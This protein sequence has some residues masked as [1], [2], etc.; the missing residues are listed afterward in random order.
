[1]A[2]L[3]IIYTVRLDLAPD[4]EEEA[5]RWNNGPHI[6]DLL[7]AGF[8]SAV[9]YRSTR[10]DPKY[11][12]LYEL[13]SIDT[14]KTETY[15]NV[16]KNDTWAPKIRHGFLNHSASL[17]KQIVTVKIKETP[18]EF[19][20]PR[21]SANSVGGVRSKYLVTI[22][23]DVA[24]DGVEEFMQ[25]NR[26]EHFHLIL[27]I[28]GMASARLCRKAGQHPKNPSH[29]PEWV[30]IYEVDDLAAL[31]D[32]RMKALNET[33][34]AKRMHQKQSDIRFNVLERVHPA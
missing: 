7:N 17:Y 5:N 9:R 12:H 22:R 18:R 15:A 4:I 28:K 29:D 20:K 26:T 3:P 32:P 10:G 27:G 21:S 11:L 8:L 23:L 25:W 6:T 1:M 30:A 14:L 16:A 31:K 33:D 13:D 2:E 19:K 24:P 34:W